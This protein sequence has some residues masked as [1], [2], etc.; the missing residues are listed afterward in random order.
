[1]IRPP[2]DGPTCPATDSPWPHAPAVVVDAPHGAVGTHQGVQAA[3]SAAPREAGPK[4]DA[5][6]D[7]VA[8]GRTGRMRWA[9]RHVAVDAGGAA[10]APWATDRS[11]RRIAITARRMDRGAHGPRFKV[12]APAL[13]ARV[14][15]DRAAVGP[16]A[17]RTPADHAP[18]DRVHPRAAARAAVRIP[19]PA[20]ADPLLHAATAARAISAARRSKHS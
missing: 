16:A 5:P 2:L 14:R 7:R 12:P 20:A 3:R 9:R 4:V 15:V 18:V 8:R 17:G 1:M 10:P 6:T 11:I 13:E 19:F